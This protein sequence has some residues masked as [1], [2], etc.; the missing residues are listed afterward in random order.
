MV[1]CQDIRNTVNASQYDGS[2]E[3]SNLNP[4]AVNLASEGFLGYSAL[5]QKP[6]WPRK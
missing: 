3:F 5:Q 4:M 6:E 2:L 1:I